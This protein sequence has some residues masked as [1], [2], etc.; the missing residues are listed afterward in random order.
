MDRILKGVGGTVRLLNYDTNADL[1]DAGGGNA[2]V[3][4]YD[5]TGTAVAGSPFTGT[6]SVVGT[7]DMTLPTSLVTLDQYQA[8][9]TMPDAS[10]RETWFELVG[11][12]L[13]AIKE[14]QSLDAVLADETA[15]PVA[16]LVEA[17]ENAEQRFEEVA[18]VS[19]TQRGARLLLDGN[20]TVDYRGDGHITTGRQQLYA[21]KSCSILDVAMGSELA[22]LVVHRHGTVTR[23]S[24]AWPLGTGNIKML[25]EHGFRAV[26]ESVR[27][28]GLLYART[29]LLR[30]AIEQSDRAT[31]VFTDIGGYRLTLAGRD[32][33]TG[34]PEVDAVLAQFGRRPAGSLA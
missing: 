31:A 24:A 25:V 6:R 17:R 13:F 19:F 11:S 26:P 20:G 23:V 34:L 33:P 29:V 7:Y 4:V 1:A 22:N 27:R 16:S 10:T 8:V 21:V 3:A 32:G 28:A 2:T 12:F 9:W 5:S 15:F 30:S 18:N 14:L